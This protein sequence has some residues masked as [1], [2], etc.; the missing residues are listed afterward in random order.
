MEVMYGSPYRYFTS[1]FLQEMEVWWWQK[2][3]RSR[4][5]QIL[6]VLHLSLIHIL[7]ESKIKNIQDYVLS[8]QH[9]VSTLTSAPT[10]IPKTL[11]SIVPS[12]HL[13]LRVRFHTFG[14]LFTCV[15]C[16]NVVGIKH[17]SCFSY[18]ITDLTKLTRILVVAN[19][20]T[21]YQ[22]TVYAVYT[23]RPFR[24]HTHVSGK[25]YWINHT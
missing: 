24:I 9:Q 21:V 18:N 12:F 2:K 14:L 20:K 3:S 6:I 22:I 16:I 5:M 15:H 23:T 7:W 11:S 8:W 10:L 4:L 25:A 17:I 19:S 13:M 1:I